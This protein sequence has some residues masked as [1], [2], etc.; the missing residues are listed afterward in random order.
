MSILS[1]KRV[2][3]YV[4]QVLVGS[5]DYDAGESD[6]YD[7]HTYYNNRL[8]TYFYYVENIY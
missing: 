2:I 7:Y 5:A 8:W 4:L 1:D 3:Q 6:E